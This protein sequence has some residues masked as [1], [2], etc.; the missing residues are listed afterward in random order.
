M[1]APSELTTRKTVPPTPEDLDHLEEEVAEEEDTTQDMDHQVAVVMGETS[2]D[3]AVVVTAEVALPKDLDL[4]AVD[5]STEEVQLRKVGAVGPAM[6]SSSLTK[7][8]KVASN[9]LTK[10]NKVAIRDSMMIGAQGLGHDMKWEGNVSECFS[11]YPVWRES[12]HKFG[13]DLLGP[14]GPGS[15][16]G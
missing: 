10:D 6:D 11:R 2:T 5:N 3:M 16:P 1:A 9:S 14:K 12:L 4:M 7:D 13:P 8:N 15:A